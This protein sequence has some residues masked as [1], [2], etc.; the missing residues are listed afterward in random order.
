M[1]CKVND[2]WLGSAGSVD[3]YKLISIGEFI[4]NDD[5]EL[6]RIVVLHISTGVLQH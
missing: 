6:A 2:S 4:G 5:D 3:D 1:V